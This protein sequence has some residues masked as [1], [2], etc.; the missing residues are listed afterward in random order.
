VVARASGSVTYLYVRATRF[1]TLTLRLAALGHTAGQTAAHMGIAPRTV[2]KHL[3]HV[4]AQL[5]VR[6]LPQAVASAWAAVGIQ[7]LTLQAPP[8]NGDHQPSPA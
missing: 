8:L 3:Q 5:G 2:E 1:Q 4:Y 7:P 6:S